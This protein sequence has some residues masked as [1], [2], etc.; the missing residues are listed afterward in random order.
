MTKCLICKEVID[1]FISFGQMPIANGFLRPDQF[2]EE[3]FFELQA[4]FCPHCTM[5]QLVEQVDPEKMFH[6]EYAFYSSTSIRMAEHFKNMAEWIKNNFLNSGDPF[7]VEMG[8]NDGIMLQNFAKSGIHHLGIDPSQ[9][10]V[11]VAKDKGIQTLCEFFNKKIA[12][13]ILTEH[14]QV[15]AFLGANVMCHIPDLHSVFSGIKQLLKPEGLLIFEDPYLGDIIEKI[16]YDQI[17]DE[18]VFLFLCSLHQL[19]C[20][21]PRP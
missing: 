1:P 21:M 2:A 17:Y 6:E 8:S 11:Q 18:H 19:S 14:G 5:V 10:V 20:R 7:V 15:D 16:S 13:D 9:N 12:G 3:Y 4:A